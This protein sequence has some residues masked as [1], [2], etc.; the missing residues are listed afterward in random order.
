MSQK[1]MMKRKIES[2]ISILRQKGLKVSSIEDKNTCF[3][4]VSEYKNKIFAL[5][6]YIPK[7][8]NYIITKL[9]VTIGGCE[10]TLYGANGLFILEE[11]ES[12]LAEKIIEK[13]E[14]MKKVNFNADLS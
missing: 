10:E 13:L 11:N 7:Y 14:Y 2:L 8:S 4:S 6:F 5:F 3:Y 9:T 1:E 12:T